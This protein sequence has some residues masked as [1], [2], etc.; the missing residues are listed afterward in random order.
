MKTG[1]DSLPIDTRFHEH[2]VISSY[3]NG[4]YLLLT[5]FVTAFHSLQYIYTGDA[6]DCFLPAVN[7]LIHVLAYDVFNCRSD[8]EL[9]STVRWIFLLTPAHPPA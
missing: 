4:P 3:P 8:M 1:I 9:L 5:N 2:S 7:I 6:P